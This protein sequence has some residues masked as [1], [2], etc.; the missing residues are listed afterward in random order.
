M[1]IKLLALCALLSVVS[2]TAQQKYL[3]PIGSNVNNRP[4][5]VSIIISSLDTW[6]RA[7]DAFDF[8]PSMGNL[9]DVVRNR[10]EK[11]LADY[12]IPANFEHGEFALNITASTGPFNQIIFRFKQSDGRW[13][14]PPDV[15]D[16]KLEYGTAVVWLVSGVTASTMQ[17]VD[18]SGTRTFSS[19]DGSGYD[20]SPCFLGA[21]RAGFQSGVAGVQVEYALPEFQRER[22]I[23]AGS[24]TLWQNERYASFDL[25]DGHF[26][27][28]SASP[29]DFLESL[30]VPEVQSVQ[31]QA[32]VL[33][34]SGPRISRISRSG[35]TT[36][37]T[38]SADS[39]SVAYLE[40]AE[41]LSG[42]WNAV[43]AYPTPLSLKSGS[44]QF[45]HTT[46][47]PMSFYR[48]RFSSS[49]Q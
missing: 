32:P 29:P 34:V 8:Q 4:A 35:N 13:T 27:G 21:S 28:V 43:P 31:S 24:V 41:A 23:T 45:T 19:A 6:A 11:L 49:P 42:N 40:F 47:A 3:L 18:A 33:V 5:K 7:E 44:T 36:E 16:T 25:L 15:L 9:E 20:D 1:K 10:A 26:L 17:V 2:A 38:V 14:I 22:G 30:R 48:L 12:Q 39:N 46:D 37:I